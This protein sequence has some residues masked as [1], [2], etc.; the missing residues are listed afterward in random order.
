MFRV[1][2]QWFW[3]VI[4]ALCMEYLLELL[5]QNI[6]RQQCPIS[7]CC[8]SVVCG[9][10]RALVEL[11]KS[12]FRNSEYWMWSFALCSFTLLLKFIVENEQVL[13]WS[14]LTDRDNWLLPE[15]CYWSLLCIYFHLN[16][17]DGKYWKYWTYQCQRRLGDGKYWGDCRWI[18]T[19]YWRRALLT[20]ERKG[21]LWHSLLLLVE[22]H[23]NWDFDT[24]RNRKEK[25][26]CS[27][28]IFVGIGGLR[29]SWHRIFSENNAE[30]MQYLSNFM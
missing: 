15:A 13:F 29:N 27:E 5:E 3:P 1:V 2:T 25:C 19:W 4:M 9:K 14:K 7:K 26:F 8:G 18:P 23:L 21:K 6:Y 12:K 16:L 28:L 22:L 30:F 10:G 24:K 11:I 17:G 20:F